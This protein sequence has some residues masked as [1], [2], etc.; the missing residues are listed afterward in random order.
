M[1]V[2]TNHTR[3][4]RKLTVK[5]HIP[6]RRTHPLLSAFS[7]RRCSAVTSE[8]GQA[9]VETALALPLMLLLSVAIFEFGRA[10]QTTQV[11]TNAVREGARVAV[12]PNATTADV[13]ARVMAYLQNGQL[14][15]YDDA[16]VLVNQN[17]S[18][19]IGTTTAAASRVTVNYPFSFIVLNPV[20]NLVVKGSTVGAPITL[21]AVAEMRNE[22]Q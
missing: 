22:A 12:L 1:A 13:Q 17:A 14:S 16:Q 7:V 3:H 4:T 8:G 20:A 21:T 11:L 9:L 10:Y 5:L 6:A 2:E 15:D 19:S 18:I